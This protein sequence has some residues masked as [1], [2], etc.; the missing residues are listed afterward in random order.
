MT[1][2]Q[3]QA[4]QKHIQA[5]AKILYEDT[6]KEKLTNLAAIE[7]AVRSQMQK[8]VMPEVGGF[9]IE[10]ITGTTAGYQRRLK[11]ILGELAIT[12][13]QA[14]ELE[15][16]PSTQLSPYLETCC[17][18]VSANVSYEDAASDIKY[19]TGIEVSHSSQQRLVHRQNFE[20]P[21]P[22]QTIEELSVDGGNIRVR[23]PKGQICAWLGYKAISLH[24]LGILGTSFQNNQIVIDWVNDQPLASPLTCIGD[25]HDGIWN[26][27][28]QLAPDAQRREIL[29]WFHLIENL[30]KV[31][32]SQKRLKQAQN[33]LWKGQVEATIALFTDCKGKQVQNFCRYLDK[34]RNRIINYEYYQAEEICSIGSG[35]VES[36]VKQVDRR[37]KISGA[38]WKRENV[39]QVLAHRCAYLN[40][41]LSV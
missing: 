36:A 22:E 14:I 23:T 19:F 4:L 39:P 38:Q 31:G 3:K 8:H 2:E 1:P 17:L 26:I 40:G 21:T 24:H 18:R 20:L 25:G 41:L 27:I 29:D 11:S 12:S 16:A 32:G 7:E 34:H 15:V 5:I 9:F 13:K 35:S 30:H 33:L 6:S 28:D 10:T 37:T